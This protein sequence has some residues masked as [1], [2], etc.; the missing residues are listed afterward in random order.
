MKEIGFSPDPAA[1]LVFRTESAEFSAENVVP[2]HVTLGTGHTEIARTAFEELRLE[3]LDTSGRQ[4][5][6]LEPGLEID[7]L[8]RLMSEQEIPP[9]TA[10][11]EIKSAAR[12]VAGFYKNKYMP[13]EVNKLLALDRKDILKLQEAL[14]LTD[15]ELEE[16]AACLILRSAVE[17]EGIGK[18]EEHE[19][20]D[21]NVV[22]EKVKRGLE[23]LPVSK[24]NR[25][26]A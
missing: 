24:A 1:K 15:F 14:R 10:V 26:A 19:Q 9:D 13:P 16:W 3:P 5:K 8:Y 25:K 23:A 21:P 18:D 2:P 17:P 6:E 4:W 20:K 22:V 12:R 11:G 7:E